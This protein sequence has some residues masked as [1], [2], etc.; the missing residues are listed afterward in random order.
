MD[1]IADMLIRIKNA[2]SSKKESVVF[3]YSK[4]K[5]EIVRIL[6]RVGYVGVVSK[7]G[8]KN[9][10]LIEAV[11]LYDANGN[12]KISNSKRLSKPSRRLYRGFREIFHPKNGYGITIYSTPKGLLTD[13]EARKEKIGGEALFELW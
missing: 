8:R 5:F 7:K 11:L 1:P 12:P 4:L 10:K 6:E 13:R 3:G 2:Q 9:K